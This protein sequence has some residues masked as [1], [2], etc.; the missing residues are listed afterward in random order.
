MTLPKNLSN[1]SALFV[2]DI[3]TTPTQN[4]SA[5][6]EFA[7]TDGGVVLPRMT[8]E[9][10]QALNPT[11]GMVIYNTDL[12]T[13]RCYQDD[14]WIS[15]A[16]HDGDVTG[17]NVSVANNIATFADDTGRLIKDSG[18]AISQVQSDDSLSDFSNI[19]PNQIGNVGYLQFTQDQ[20]SVF[21]NG[22]TAF[23]IFENGNLASTVF[24]GSL[25]S[26]TGASSV[27]ALVELQSTE[28]ALLLSRLTTAEIN[29]LANPQP[30]M[31]VY[32]T[33]VNA[34]QTYNGTTWGADAGGTVTEV[35]TGVGLS[36]GP[37]TGMGTLSLANTSVNAGN[38]T[39]ANITVNAQGQIITASN[40]VTGVQSVQ[41][42][43]YNTA[44]SYTHTFSQ[45]MLFCLVQVC[46]AGGGGQSPGAGTGEG[47]TGAAGGYTQKLWNN[48]NINPGSVIPLVVGGGG[49][50]GVGSAGQDGG[51]SSFG[52]APWLTATGGSGGGVSTLGG[53]GGGG[54]IN[55]YGEM[56]ACS[57]SATCQGV[58]NII[59]PRG[60]NSVFGGQGGLGRCNSNQRTLGIFNGQ[61]PGCGGQ[62]SYTSSGQPQSTAG[63][64]ANGIVIITEYLSSG[65]AQ[66][67]AIQ[68][69]RAEPKKLEDK[70]ARRGLW[71][72]IRSLWR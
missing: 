24:T 62:A 51:T 45:N 64:G 2:S 25:P 6:A 18:I 38:Y 50:G 8:N 27:S 49:Q 58:S 66:E 23:Q 63:N 67:D 14:E 17:P 34:Q 68:D 42:T 22:E 57:F 54:D 30:G 28:G 53:L 36:G 29:V 70:T 48:S 20:G 72:T 40:G 59:L 43:T 26:G 10:E 1:F 7:S 4:I 32:N 52:P 9:E 15:L 33:D 16:G 69:L 47:N 37:I 61:N 19:N 60:G 12:G 13:L 41:V 44:G 35:N 21:L 3:Q 46:G 65:S 39:N 71:T 55:L 31:I 11:S 56:G 5:V